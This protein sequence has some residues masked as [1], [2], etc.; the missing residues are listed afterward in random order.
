MSGLRVLVENGVRV[1]A[2]LVP[3]SSKEF[4]LQRARG[5]YTG[6]RTVSR[7]RVWLFDAHLRR[8]ANSYTTI[9]HRQI[10]ADTVRDAVMPSL[11]LAVSEFLR[12]SKLESDAELK[13]TLLLSPNA[14][15]SINDASSSSSSTKESPEVGVYVELQPVRSPPIAVEFRAHEPRPQPEA[16]DT[17]WVSARAVFEREKAADA[18]EVVMYSGD[19]MVV[20]EGLSSNFAVLVDGAIH[21][22]PKNTV[23]FGTVFQLIERLARAHSIPLHLD[24]IRVADRSRWQAAFIA[25]TTRGLL[26]IDVVRF[27]DLPNEPP[28]QLPTDVPTFVT[29]RKLI[30]DEMINESTEIVESPGT[31]TSND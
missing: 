25:S 20:S 29:L 16:K 2:A 23:L 28:L 30:A 5:T 31:A 17:A 26:P 7:T 11:R 1:P 27:I 24:G 18:D 9:T 14:S 15:N 6:I 4:I 19:D 21:T 10:D 22:A 13:L 8:L 12:A 3:S